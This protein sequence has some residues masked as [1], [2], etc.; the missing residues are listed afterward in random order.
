MSLL[1]NKKAKMKKQI[2]DRYKK[3]T[4]AIENKKK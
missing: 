3:L 1:D 2:G 4:D